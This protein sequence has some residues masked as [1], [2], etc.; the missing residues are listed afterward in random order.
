MYFIHYIVLQRNIE[1]SS[2][3]LLF[4]LVTTHADI[5]IWSDFEPK[6]LRIPLPDRVYLFFPSPLLPT[7]YL[8]KL[9]PGMSVRGKTF[10]IR[11]SVLCLSWPVK[12]LSARLVVL[13]GFESGP[14]LHGSLLHKR[15]SS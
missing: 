10:L 14:V 8:T 5:N 15:T 12:I 13:P 7:R 3:F 9:M 6:Y 2:D 1:W 11:G 4:G